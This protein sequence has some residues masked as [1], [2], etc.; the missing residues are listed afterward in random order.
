MGTYKSYS[1]T[2]IYPVG[3]R[4]TTNANT[5]TN[6]DKRKMAVNSTSK[7]LILSSKSPLSLA[8]RGVSAAAAPKEEK[9]AWGLRS[10]KEKTSLSTDGPTRRPRDEDRNE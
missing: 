3:P 8:I 4:R 1:E 5:N 2:E 6:T 9:G 7:V 10:E